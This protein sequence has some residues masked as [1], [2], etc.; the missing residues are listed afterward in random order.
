VRKTTRSQFAR[1]MSSRAMVDEA[2]DS[3]VVL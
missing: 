3:R 1:H 2:V